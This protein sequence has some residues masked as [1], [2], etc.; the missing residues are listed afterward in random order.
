MQTDI[1]V[2]G[3]GNTGFPVAANLSL[4]GCS[5]TLAELPDFREAIDPVREAQAIELRGVARVGVAKIAM[6]TDNVAAAVAAVRL[7]QFDPCWA[8]GRAVAR[9]LRSEAVGVRLFCLRLLPSRS[10]H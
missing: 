7:V 4:A 8:P 10:Y 1:T 6:I 2:F 3:A 9:L 5:V